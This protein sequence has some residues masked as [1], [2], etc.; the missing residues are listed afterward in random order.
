MYWNGAVNPAHDP[1]DKIWNPDP[2]LYILAD[3]TDNN[4]LTIFKKPL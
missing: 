4:V 2:V 1:F 3:F